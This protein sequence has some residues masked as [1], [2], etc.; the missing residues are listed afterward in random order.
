ML[1]GNGDINCDRLPCRQGRVCRSLHAVYF[2]SNR[3]VFTMEDQLFYTITEGQEMITLTQFT[4]VS[5]D[6]RGSFPR[7][8]L[9]SNAN[10]SSAGFKK[11]RFVDV[12]PSTAGLRPCDEASVAQLCWT[13]HDGQGSV[14]EVR[15][16]LFLLFMCFFSQQHIRLTDAG[17]PVTA[18][19]TAFPQR[20][21]HLFF[22]LFKMGKT[23]KMEKMRE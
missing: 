4:S 12:W 13:S 16:I 3:L 8:W 6:P 14:P 17:Y 23:E 21:F 2:H 20:P 10:I 9:S 7:V 19:S 18:T 15:K 5:A 1:I 11:D 22:F